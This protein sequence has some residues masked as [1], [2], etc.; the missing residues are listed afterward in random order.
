MYQQNMLLKLWK[1][2]LKY[3][4]NKYHVDWLS[5]SKHLKLP[6]NIKIPVTIGQI[7]YI[8]MAA[9]SSNLIS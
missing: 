7:V 4:P 9:I 6:I 2:I 1:L 3:T 5:S 8:Y